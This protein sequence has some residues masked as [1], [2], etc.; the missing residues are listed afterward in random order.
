[1]TQVKTRPPAFVVMTSR[2]QDLPESYSCYLVN[3]LRAAFDMPGTP[4]R[5]ILRSPA[6]KNPCKDRKVPQPSALRKH[7][8]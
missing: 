4:V 5:L 7:L 8:G 2:P 6:E 3:G 1:M